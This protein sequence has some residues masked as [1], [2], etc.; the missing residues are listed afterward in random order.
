MIDSP[1]NQY[2]KHWWAMREGGWLDAI[3][4]VVIQ[5]STGH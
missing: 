5:Y 1:M 2:H 4:D 3:M